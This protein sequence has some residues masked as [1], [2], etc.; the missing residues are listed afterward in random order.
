VVIWP[1]KETG[2]ER[3]TLVWTN[4]ETVALRCEKKLTKKRKDV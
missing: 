1:S 4:R 3:C 2:V